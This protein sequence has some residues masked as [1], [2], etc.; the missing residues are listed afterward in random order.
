MGQYYK[1]IFLSNDGKINGWTESF[2]GVKMM[3]HAFQDEPVVRFIQDKIYNKPTAIVWAGDYA[4]PEEI[5]CS[6]EN[7]INALHYIIRNHSELHSSDQHYVEKAKAILARKYTENFNDDDCICM[8]FALNSYRKNLY[9]MCDDVVYKHMPY[10]IYDANYYKL[11]KYLLNHT[12][13]EY[14]DVLKNNNQDEEQYEKD[15]ASRLHPLPLL[16]AETGTGGGGDYRGVGVEDVGIWARD[17]IS[18]ADEVPEG[19]TELEVKFSW[20]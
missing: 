1:A 9:T 13:K 6:L 7:A 17:L 11:H 8:T 14:I 4:E 20:Y 12:K 10:N 16:T 19:F 18:T 2:G 3:E 15:K 5:P